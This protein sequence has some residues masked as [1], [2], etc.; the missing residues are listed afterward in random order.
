M[1]RHSYLRDLHGLDLARVAYV[2]PSTQ[3]NEWATLVHSGRGSVN[4]LVN[5]PQLKLVVLQV[6]HTV[7]LNTA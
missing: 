4:L 6:I 7:P 1:Q 2:G 5:D 3:V